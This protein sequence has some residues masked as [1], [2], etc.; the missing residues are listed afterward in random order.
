MP[1]ILSCLL[2]VMKTRRMT[3]FINNKPDNRATFSSRVSLVR[4]SSTSKVDIGDSILEIVMGTIYRDSC[5]RGNFKDKLYNKKEAL[6][7]FLSDPSYCIETIPHV[8][9]LG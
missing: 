2:S 8:E 9:I 1:K 5:F 4:T 7:E 6:S 3:V